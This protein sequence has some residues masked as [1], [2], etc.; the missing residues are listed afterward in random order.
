MSNEMMLTFV[1]L[2]VAVILFITELIRVD[3]VG[4]AVL[5]ALALTN[6]VEP[7]EALVGFSNPA[8]VTVWAM[9]ILSAGLS[10]T[11]VSRSGAG[12]ETAPKD[13]RRSRASIPQPAL[14]INMT[15]SKLHVRSF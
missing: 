13:E 1:I 5:T 10:R 8:V 12:V 2:A 14:T 7:Q 11:G 3:L 9:F 6:L 4:L 15:N